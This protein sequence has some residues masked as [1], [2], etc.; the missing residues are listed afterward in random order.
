MVLGW[1]VFGYKVRNFGP[2][3]Y[4]TAED[5]R[6]TL[7]ARLRLMCQ[8]LELSPQ[9]T[10]RVRQNIHILDVSGHGIK[11]TQVVKDVVVPTEYVPKLIEKL[12]PYQ[13]AAVMIDPAV[14]F[15]VGESRVNDAEQGLVDAA[16]RIRNELLCAV[17][18]V[19]HTGKQNARE[20]TLDQY[21]N[22][23]GSALP[24]GCRMVH[25]MQSLTP[26][27]WTEKTGDT[28]EEGESGI[29]YARPK[30]TWA[31][32]NQPTIYI[33]RKGYLFTRFDHIAGTDGAKLSLERNSTKIDQFLR[34]G[35]SKNERYT[36]KTLEATGV[37]K[38][39]NALRAAVNHMIAQGKVVEED[40]PTSGRGRPPKLLRPR[41]G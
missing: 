26:E 1:E 34:E 36:L 10:L 6:A 39:R 27:E 31:P 23:G 20:K 24:D 18:Y 32:A 40:A 28:L 9:Q 11:L 8:E 30:I 14:S 2:V 15:G 17:I 7:L 38:P 19:H 3:I 16:R 41:D 25:V 4:L 13:P 21:S 22:R 33:K 35:W 12:K 37:V 5:D 29:V